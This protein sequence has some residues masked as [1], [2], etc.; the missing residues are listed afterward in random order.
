[1]ADK[2]A[3]KI[4]ETEAPRT[5]PV[6]HKEV[7]VTHQSK[8]PLIGIA[9]ALGLIVLLVGAGSGFLAGLAVGKHTNGRSALGVQ[10]PLYGGRQAPTYQGQMGRGVSRTFF[11][12]TGTVTDVSSS[13]ISVKTNRGTT[14]TYVITSSTTVSNGGNSASVSDIKVGDTVSVRQ[15]TDT[16]GDVASIQINP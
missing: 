5:E 16:T 1:M 8:A 7:T 15:T 9:V 4:E 6:H 12:T 11:S 13:S 14:V 2:E 10:S 3:P